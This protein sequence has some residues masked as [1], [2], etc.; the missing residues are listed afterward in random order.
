MPNNPA[1]LLIDDEPQMLLSYKVMLRT[2]GF[3][4]MLTA[5]DSRIVLKLLAE[6]K[7]SVVVLDLNM[8]H[9]TGD[10]LL[11][12]INRGF[13]DMAVI[14]VTAENEVERAVECMKKGALDYHVKPVGDERLVSSIKRALEFKVLK[15]E[16][17]SL[18]Q[19]ILS[20]RTNLLKD[21]LEHEH[22]FSSILTQSRKMQNVFHYIETTAKTE[23]P[24]LILGET[25]VGKELISKAI[26]YISN[27]EGK[28]VAVNVA[29]VDDH[30]FSDT[31]FGHKKGA[32]TGA[33]KE[34][35]GLIVKAS[36]GT[37]LLD[38]IGDL[39]DMSQVKLL[40]LIED[41]TYYPLG[42]DIPEMSNARIIAATNRDIHAMV[43]EG[44]FRE[45]LYYRLSTIQVN[46]PS[47]KDRFEDLPILVDHF[48]EI[49]AK[50]LKK[51]KPVPPPEIISLLSSYHFPGNIRELKAVIFDAVAKHTSGVLSLRSIKDYIIKKG[52]HLQPAISIP[53]KGF[54]ALP[55]LEG[56]FPTIKEIEDFIV[57]EALKRS[58]GNQGIAASLLGITRQ[59]LNTRLRKANKSL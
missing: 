30:V 52:K 37:I 54:P 40:R 21:K 59:A 49:S 56:R 33:D 2:E 16:V 35:K 44:T 41:G 29:G 43:S 11:L 46:I 23:E 5:S 8:P 26:H 7:V 17:S 36:D 1:I 6:N 18:R 4:N 12:E 20:L 19:H 24:I 42:S 51:K 14:I 50:S 10:E 39:N 13:P 58:N 48:I 47:L 3:D 34:R 28:L 9:V 22:A 15:N 38:E 25:G 55:D 53:E 32:F 27:V 31:L 57:S 45:D